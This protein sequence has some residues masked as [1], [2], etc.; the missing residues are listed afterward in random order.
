MF[1]AATSHPPESDG[2][3]EML[4]HPDGFRDM[5][6]D[7][8]DVF[9][10]HADLTETN[11]MVSGQPGSYRVSGII[12]WEQSG[13]YPMYWE[14]CKMTGSLLWEEEDWPSKVADAPTKEVDFVVSEYRMWRNGWT[15]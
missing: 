9:F 6:P 5:L 7:N 14:F 1:A 12:D 11:I 15:E 8:C 4:D 3:I 2:P 13:W 10:A